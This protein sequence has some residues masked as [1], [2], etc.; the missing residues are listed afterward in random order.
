MFI[1][2][3]SDKLGSRKKWS[4]TEPF[5]EKRFLPKSQQIALS[6]TAKKSFVSG[7]AS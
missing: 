7:E 1:P 2:G 5:M 6:Q 4:L 3:H